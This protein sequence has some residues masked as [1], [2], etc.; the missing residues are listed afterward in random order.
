MPTNCAH[1]TVLANLRLGQDGNTERLKKEDSTRDEEAE[2][3][4]GS[5]DKST[6]VAASW[7]PYAMNTFLCLNITWHNTSPYL[8]SRAMLIH[9]DSTQL[10]DQQVLQ[11]T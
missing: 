4:G 10:S 6:V 3:V 8:C 2:V 9:E 11:D 5:R 7:H 1:D